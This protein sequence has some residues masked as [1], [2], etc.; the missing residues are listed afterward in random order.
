MGLPS[1]ERSSVGTPSSIVHVF[2]SCNME[3]WNKVGM[4]TSSC[5]PF[6]YVHFCVC[7]CSNKDH[8]SLLVVMS[9]RKIHLRQDAV[10][11]LCASDEPCLQTL[12][13]SLRKLPDVDRM[14]CSAYHRKMGIS[15]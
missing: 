14:L 6:S 15:D 3:A 5:V 2:I 4:Q 13:Q 1:S 9:C 10:K 8:A 11:E 7:S 12:A